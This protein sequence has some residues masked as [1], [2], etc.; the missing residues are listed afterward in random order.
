[1]MNAPPRLKIVITHGEINAETTL[2]SIRN[3]HDW[4]RVERY[5]PHHNTE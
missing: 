1:M 3:R 4:R 2:R 5:A